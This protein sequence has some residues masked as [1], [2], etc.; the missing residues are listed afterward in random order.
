MA[1]TRL[2]NLRPAEFD[3]NGNPYLNARLFFY[4]AG[5]T[6]KQDTF[7]DSAGAVP[8]T[9]PIVLNARG[10]PNVS[11]Y[12][13]TGL[14]YDIGLAAPGNDDPPSSFIWVEGGINNLTDA[15]DLTFTQAGAH[16]LTRLIET[17][18]REIVRSTQFS[19]TPTQKVQRAI[20]EI[21][22]SGAGIVLLPR[23]PLTLGDLLIPA[24]IELRG[25][26]II[27]TI[28]TYSGSGTF[29]LL[30]GASALNYFGCGISGMKVISSSDTVLFVNA[31]GVIYGEISDLLLEGPINDVRT[32]RGVVIDGMNASSFG[33][34]IGNVT[35]N[36]MH[37]SFILQSTGTAPGT[38]Y[39]TS[40]YFSNCY[41]LGDVATDPDSTGV[42]IGGH[43]GNG[44]VFN[45]GNIENCGIGINFKT[46]CGTVT[47]IGTRFEPDNTIDINYEVTPNPQIFLGCKNMD[48][49]KIIDA[50]GTGF[51][52]HTYWGCVDLHGNVF[53]NI[54]HETRLIAAQSSSVALTLKG[55]PT[56]TKPLQ[57]NRDSSDSLMSYVKSNGI[58]NDSSLRLSNDRGDMNVTL[59][60]GVDVGHQIFATALT[61]NRTVTISPTGAENG[62]SFRITRTAGGAFNLTVNGGKVIGIS[63]WADYTLGALG[64]VL[65]AFG[66]L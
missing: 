5:T 61:A 11:I 31:Q 8:N 24:G 32:T 27:G 52:R 10:E 55:Y 48:S 21:E 46:G 36:H 58:Y 53:E 43:S 57:E 2:T 42:E 33:M 6:I 26:G 49:T 12:V 41:A 13:T 51:E 22:P 1:V 44:T 16:A 63:Q 45:G 66:S 14:S 50:S 23:G 39:P 35:C 40:Q 56:S 47:F 19:G 65:T 25:Q 17:E 20:D 34:K 54:S 62:D 29:A 9:N 60:V 64:W 38:T 18:L 7:S 28:V 3:A 30:G 15:S 37:K 4:A 59:V